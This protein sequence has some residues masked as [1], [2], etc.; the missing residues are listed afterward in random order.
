MIALPEWVD[1]TLAATYGLTPRQIDILAGC[2]KGMT[3]AQIGRA[4][5]L[6]EDTVKTHAKALFRNLRVGDR[7]AAVAV[8]YDVG[9]FRTRAMRVQR[10]GLTVVPVLVGDAA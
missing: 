5:Y 6:S 4:L 8:A 1:H 3:N 10:S 9:V 7:A 2:A